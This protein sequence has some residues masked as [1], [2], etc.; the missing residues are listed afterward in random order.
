MNLI[1]IRVYLHV[2][3]VR[4]SPVASH[5]AF[6]LKLTSLLYIPPTGSRT[7]GTIV[8]DWLLHHFK[9]LYIANLYKL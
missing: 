3:A 4:H 2:S 9:I 5:L 6:T 8:D 7:I 1:L